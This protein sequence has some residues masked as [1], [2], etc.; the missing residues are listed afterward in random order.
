MNDVHN[1]DP[2]TNAVYGSIKTGIEV[3]L[4]E[5]CAGSAI[6]LIYSG[7]DTMAFLSMPASQV[8]VTGVDFANWCDRYIQLPGEQV[9]GLE[10][11]AARCAVVHTFGIES[12]LSRQGKC[13]TIG[14]SFVGAHPTVYDPAI[15]PNFV[16]LS[17]DALSQAFFAG[18]DRFLVDL[19]ADPARRP[20]VEQRIKKLLMFL[21]RQYVD[22][23]AVEMGYPAASSFREASD[24]S[25]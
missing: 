7:I 18:I 15:E 10:L 17:L 25:D 22:E 24:A 12:K 6:V 14:Y 3:C 21:P 1:S 2:L 13:R 5:M 11:F 4:K 16:V 9:T 23:K 8:E 20:T 19:F